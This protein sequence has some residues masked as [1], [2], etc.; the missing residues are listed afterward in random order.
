MRAVAVLAVL[1]YHANSSWLKAGYVGVD[2]FFV[3]S[4]FIIT[5][6]LTER[7]DKVDLLAFYVSRIKRI[8]PAYFVMLVVVCA[9]SSVFF[10]PDD[11]AFFLDSLKSSAL[12]TSNQYFAGFGSYFAP[13]ADELPLLHTWSLAIEMQFYLF[14]PF[15]V[16]C[17][18]KRWRLPVFVLLAISLFAW[19]GYGLLGGSRD[20]LYFALSARTPEFMVG[21]VV[22]C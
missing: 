1:A 10:V 22:A 12:F 15:L 18:P 14:F 13:R 2:V 16:L 21:A 17:S 9:L 19:C 5:A 7:S 6:L 20:G 11:F 3:I 4:G 8:L